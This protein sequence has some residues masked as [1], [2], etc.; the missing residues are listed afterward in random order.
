M[1]STFNPH[2]SVFSDTDVD[3]NCRFH[4]VSAILLGS[5]PTG[6]LVEGI[7]KGCR[8]HPVQADRSHQ[9]ALSI[10]RGCALCDP[11]YFHATKGQPIDW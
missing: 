8:K 1:K 3:G 2:I 5:C 4:A 11:L 10:K 7:L 6:R 9:L